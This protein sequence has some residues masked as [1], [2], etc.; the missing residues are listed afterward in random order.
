[1]SF[2]EKILFFISLLGAFNAFILGVYFIFFTAK[3]YLPNYLLGGLLMVLSIRIGKSVIYFFDA[4]LPRT[5][6]QIGL[7]ACLF[8]GPFLYF[9]IKSEIRKIK[10][11]P[12]LWLWQL[13]A[14][15]VLIVVIGVIYPYQYFAPLWW[16]YIIPLIYFQ[17]GIYIVFS[18]FLL[19]PIIKRVFGKEEIKVFEKWIL[20]ICGGVLLLF[21]SYVWAFFNITKGSYIHAAIFF[22]LIIYLV[23]FTLLYRKKTNDLSSFSLQK[24][25]D[26]K[27]DTEEV[28]QIVG[29]LTLV[30]TEKELFKNPNLKISELAKAINIS[31]HQLSQILNESIDKNFTLF[32]NEY[33]INEACKLLLSNPNLTVEA[34]A[35]EVGFNAKST[36]FAAFKKIQGITPSVYQK[37]NT[38]EL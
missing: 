3:K 15:F 38:P 14:W 24:Y 9:F 7:T 17:W 25:V 36:F 19:M 12:R 1:M 22:S 4:N 2:A 27:I 5:F 34:V 35:D 37:L 26:K 10:R 20:T 23:I 33:R 8:I 21:V 16:H 13:V 32:V 18:V 29:K 6:L 11:L 30:M 28:K 31:T